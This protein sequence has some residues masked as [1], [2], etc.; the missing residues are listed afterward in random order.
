MGG[1]N[2]FGKCHQARIDGSFVARRMQEL[3]KEW[4]T[5]GV[6]LVPLASALQPRETGCFYSSSRQR[7]ALDSTI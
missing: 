5:N 2:A 3:L 6:E 7:L 1:S 4:Q